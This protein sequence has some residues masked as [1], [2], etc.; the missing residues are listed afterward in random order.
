M[1]GPR[2]QV[3]V[4]GNRHLLFMTPQALRKRWTTTD[5]LSL[6]RR[7][8]EAVL[9]KQ[10]FNGLGLDGFDGRIDL[11]GFRFPAP[12]EVASFDVEGTN[13]RL[14]EHVGLLRLEGL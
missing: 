12:V 7:V 13:L 14:G 8:V 9:Q 6:S 4:E 5:G 1:E 3:R 11:R 2:A 10:P